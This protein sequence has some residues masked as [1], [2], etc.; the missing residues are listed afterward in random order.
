[1]ILR[2]FDG[3][4]PQRGTGAQGALT[5]LLRLLLTVLPVR[6]QGAPAVPSTALALRTAPAA[7][8]GSEYGE[9]LRMR[10]SVGLQTDRM[11]QS[12]MFSGLKLA[13]GP[14]GPI[15]PSYMSLTIALSRVFDPKGV[16]SGAIRAGQPAAKGRM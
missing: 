8:W 14:C 15:A 5:F 10:L 13:S 16:G 3:R 4:P 2:L 9:V 7:S 6:Q 12:L 1:M 11:F